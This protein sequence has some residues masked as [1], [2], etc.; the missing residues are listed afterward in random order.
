MHLLPSSSYLHR[1]YI[2]SVVVASIV[3]VTTFAEVVATDITYTLVASSVWSTVEQAIGIICACLPILPALFTRL[4]GL[5]RQK[6]RSG[7][8]YPQSGPSTKLAQLAEA[9]QGNAATTETDSVGVSR[10]GFFRL[11]E[12]RWEGEHLGMSQKS[13][14]T[15]VTANGAR[16]H[17]DEGSEM[18]RAI[19]KNQI[20][21][22]AF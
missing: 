1:H 17:G 8:S 11:D 19:V 12:E 10:G 18:P 3:R 13:V 4:L 15:N 2:P 6:A 7:E 5:S 16:R 21:R 14:E 22:A 20:Y 9:K